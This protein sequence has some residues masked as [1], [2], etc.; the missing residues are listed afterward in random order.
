MLIKH[1]SNTVILLYVFVVLEWQFKASVH[2]PW[3]GFCI[4]SG[5]QHH[6]VTYT[7]K[8]PCRQ[9][10]SSKVMAG[11]IL[12]SMIL[13]RFCC[14]TYV[15]VVHSQNITLALIQS[16]SFTWPLSVDHPY[17]HKMFCPLDQTTHLW[18]SMYVHRHADLEAVCE[19]PALLAILQ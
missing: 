4:P 1:D 8:Q 9:L 14:W 3:Q 7:P 15:L 5:R 16:L 6:Y 2:N 18:A 17:C 19:M 12:V 10:L 11:F 13:W